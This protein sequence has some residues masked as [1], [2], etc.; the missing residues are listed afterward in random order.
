MAELESR[1]RWSRA[2]VE[3]Y[4]L[5]RVNVLWAR[6]TR[7]VPFYH[8]LSRQLGLPERFRGLDEYCSLVP[9]LTKEIVQ[10]QPRR[11][12]SSE[13]GP[14]G[15]RRTGGSTGQ[16]LSVFESRNAPNVMCYRYRHLAMWN[17]DIFDRAAMLWNQGNKFLPGLAGRMARLTLPVEDYL[18][19]RIRLSAYQLGP[20]DLP[21]HLERLERFGPRHIYGF[22]RALLLLAREARRRGFACPPLSLATLSGEPAPPFLVKEVESGL[23]VSAV[24]EYGATECGV[25]AFEGPDRRLRVREDAVLVETFP[26]PDGR[27]GIII[28]PLDNA[29]FPLLRYSIDDL[30]DQAIERPDVGFAVLTNVLGRNN[31]L[32][33]T[34]SGRYLHAGRFEGVLKRYDAIRR[35]RIYQDRAGDLAVSLELSGPA[36]SVDCRGLEDQIRELVEGYRVQVE[37]VDVIPQT[38]AGKHRLVIS[39]VDPCREPSSA[40]ASP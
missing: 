2:E 36:N 16:P 18:R 13:A 38:P 23:K 34:R 17:I 32:V 14:G 19:N 21:R 27:F 1:E 31:D 40:T 6:A 25:I 28:T 39:E 24:V 12:L 29:D 33:R 26:R 3:A 8:D 37:I 5:E 7:T 10:N 4:Q 30:S 35:F 15:W 11:F 22:S 20:S 9:P